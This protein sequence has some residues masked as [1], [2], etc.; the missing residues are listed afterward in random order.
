L[1]AALT[2]K[3][4]AGIAPVLTNPEGFWKTLAATPENFGSLLNVMYFISIPLIWIAV[5]AGNN[6]WEVIQD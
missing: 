3:G 6:I 5:W 1:G 2:I 4:M